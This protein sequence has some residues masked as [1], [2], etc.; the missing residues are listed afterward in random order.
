MGKATTY[1]KGNKVEYT[2]IAA[3]LYGALFY[4]VRVL[5]GHEKGQLKHIVKPPPARA[6]HRPTRRA[7]MP[8]ST[9]SEESWEYGDY[10]RDRNR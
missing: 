5:E 8:P 10:M 9:I 2:G 4:E 1:F 7:P 6:A 3:V